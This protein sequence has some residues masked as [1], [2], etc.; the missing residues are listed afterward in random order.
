MI[1]EQQDP[2]DEA[3]A[4]ALVE[5]YKKYPVWEGAHESANSVRA[6]V[7]R[8]ASIGGYRHSEGV[9]YSKNYSWLKLLE[10][11]AVEDLRIPPDELLAIY[12][13]IY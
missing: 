13:L 11:L 1:D 7:Y 8:K 9:D 2:R 3:F 6:S 12:S 10:Q 4:A 5:L